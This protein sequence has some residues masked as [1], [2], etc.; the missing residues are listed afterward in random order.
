MPIKLW[1]WSFAVRSSRSFY[2]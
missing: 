1:I 2:K